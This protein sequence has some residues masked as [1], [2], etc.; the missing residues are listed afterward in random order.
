MTRIPDFIQPDFRRNEVIAFIRDGLRDMS[1]TRANRGWGIPVPG[2]ESRVIYVWFDAL[3]NYIAATG[4]P[5]DPDWESL[6]PAD[7]HLVGKEILVRFH[8]TLWPA[9]LMALDLPLPKQVYAHGWWTVQGAKGGKTGASL[10]HPTRLTQLLADRSGA[11]FEIAADAV[12]YV[13]CREM[14]FGPDTEFTIENCLHR[15]NTDLANGVG[16]LVHR[17]LSMMGRYYDGIVPAIVS[18]D[19]Q[20]AALVTQAQSEY[21]R[22]M[23]DFRLNIAL[24]AVGTLVNGVNKYLVERAPWELAKRAQ[25]GDE[26]A[27]SALAQT[28]T[29]CLEATRIVSVL[30]APFLPVAADALR[31]QLGITQPVAEARWEDLQ[32]GGLRAG[33]KVGPPTPVFPRIQDLM[34]DEATRTALGSAAQPLMTADERCEVI[35]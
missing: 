6:W 30:V 2:D 20:I 23:T 21:E 27:R 15:Y 29:G 1:V 19:P 10:P 28:L 34:V 9:M 12:R 16:N 11:S 24:E 31:A 7:V 35:G 33:T 14:N 22:A 26:S 13:L 18:L 3:I 4:W 32:S 25:A 17:T 8:A 5:D